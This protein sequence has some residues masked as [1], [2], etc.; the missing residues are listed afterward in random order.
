MF[1]ISSSAFHPNLYDTYDGLSFIIQP[2]RSVEFGN[3]TTEDAQ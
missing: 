2:I 1:S 3:L